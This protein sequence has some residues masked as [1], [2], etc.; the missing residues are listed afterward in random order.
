MMEKS[1]FERAELH[2]ISADGHRSVMQV[3]DIVFYAL[4]KVTG[5][6]FGIRNGEQRYY[7]YPDEKILENIR[8][9][10]RGT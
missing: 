9:I 2:I 5:L 1:G 10:D 3:K 7:V 8:K 4:C 6:Q